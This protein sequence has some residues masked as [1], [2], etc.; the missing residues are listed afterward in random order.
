MKQIQ[1]QL[2]KMVLSQRLHKQFWITQQ[3]KQKNL[4]YFLHKEKR[5]FQ[6]QTKYSFCGYTELKQPKMW[7]RNEVK[8]IG[9]NLHPTWSQV[10]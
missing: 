4:F 9:N 6:G 3:N 2:Q 5:I 8:S 7:D 1:L 10:I